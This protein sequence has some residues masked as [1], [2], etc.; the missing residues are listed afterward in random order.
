MRIIKGEGCYWAVGSHS[1]ARLP[2]PA[3]DADGTPVEEAQE[4]LRRSGIDQDRG[5]SIYHVTALITTKCNLACSYCFQN[6]E[7]PP[8]GRKGVP[9]RIPGATLDAARIDDILG[10]VDRQMHRY[11]ARELDVM[12]FGGEP[13][14]HMDMCLRLLTGA[15]SLG[16]VTASMI[17]NGTLFTVADMRR[18]EAAGLRSVQ[19]TLDGDA[20]THDRSRITVGGHGTFEKI[21]HNLQAASRHT[22]I[23]WQLRVNLTAETIAGAD[24]LIDRI[25]ARLDP[26]K[27]AFSFALVN[28]PGL[29]YAGAMAHSPALARRVGTLYEH[30]VAAGFVVPV[31]STAP[32]VA[33]G[34]V[35][36]RSGAV[37]NA[38]GT[39]Y[40]CWESAGRAGMEVGTVAEGYLSE[41][42]VVSRWVAC[43]YNAR[44][45]TDPQAEQDYRDTLDALVLDS[46][47]RKGRL[48]AATVHRATGMKTA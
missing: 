10:F 42:L 11:G 26:A 19:V 44:R 43:E 41:E 45:R 48:G 9:V 46:L 6:M 20:A 22:E 35:G 4:L 5:T 33:C 27:C 13:T 3:V 23:A 37:V 1:V 38:D 16:P 25:A 28:D 47:Y 40:S 21:M 17:S 32:C 36:G 24:T 30:A 12:L 7:I 15:R 39:L 14:L 34:E 18:L 31:P 29:G 2:S 8:A